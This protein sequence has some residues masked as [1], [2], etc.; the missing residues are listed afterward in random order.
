MVGNVFSVDNSRFYFICQT[1][2]FITGAY[3]IND[4]SL[5][6][7]MEKAVQKRTLLCFLKWFKEKLR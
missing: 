4:I 7:S 1:F 3:L 6:N 5:G 2:G